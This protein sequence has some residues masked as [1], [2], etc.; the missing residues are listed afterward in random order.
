MSV[1]SSV[2]HILA[3]VPLNN[4]YEHTLYFETR[5]EQTTYFL[6]RKV[7]TFDKFSYLRPDQVI[8]VAG[9]V[10][11]ARTWNYLMFQNDAGKWYYHFINKVVYL[12]DSAVELHIDLDVMQTFQFDWNL[13]ECFIERTHTKTDEFGEHTIPEG[14][15]TGPLIRYAQSPVDMGDMCIMILMS[16][17]STGDQVWGKMYGGVYSGL[18]AYAVD[19]SKINKL[20]EWFGL[21]NRDGFI[22]AIV[23]MWMYPKG[24]VSIEGDW[25]SDSTILHTV[26]N[27]RQDIEINL[28]DPFHDGISI[29]GARVYNN[30]LFTYPYTMLYISNNMG[31]CAVYHRER[32]DTDQTHT[33]KLEGALSPDS[34]VQLSPRGYKKVGGDLYNYEEGLSLPA[35]PTCAWHSD[36]YLVWLAQNQ[37]A[38]KFTQ[39]QATIQAGAGALSAVASIPTGN[40]NGALAGLGAGVQALFQTQQLMAQKADMALQ[41]DQARGNHS[42]SINMTHGRPGFS[43][44]WMCITKEYARSI[45]DYFTR[46]GYKI[47]RV[48][49]PQLH[50]RPLFTYI[51]TVG[52][53]VTGEMGAEDQLKIQAIFDKG[54]T[55]WADPDEVGNFDATSN[56]PS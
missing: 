56:M 48:D 20:N 15:E 26:T 51:K 18:A 37:N 12:N 7:K 38:H 50:N 25:D 33:F 35:F 40:I 28:D 13:H 21:A 14:L 16:T 2:I 49:V 42:G 4:S 11:N 36:T 39:A 44:Y 1:P 54:V 34:G 22:D 45:D 43:A 41:P 27:V 46:Y 6:G 24:M 8:K 3:G 47:N 17:N 53:L 32:F 52:S 31:G 19:T 23:S 30:K 9:D 5:A 29:D 10:A 55:F